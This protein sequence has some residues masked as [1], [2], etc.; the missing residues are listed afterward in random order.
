MNRLDFRVKFFKLN[1]CSAALILPEF[2]RIIQKHSSFLPSQTYHKIIFL[3]CLAGFFLYSPEILFSKNWFDNY[4]HRSKDQIEL[5]EFADRHLTDTRNLLNLN[6]LWEARKKGEKSWTQV[7]VPGAYDFEGEVE[8]KRK[9]AI[10]SSLAGYHFELVAFGIKNRCRLILNNEFLARHEGGHTSFTTD[11]TEKIKPG[12]QNELVIV[13]DNK[14]SPQSSLP[15]KHNPHMPYNYGGIFRDIFIL[16]TPIIFVD[17]LEIRRDFTEDLQRC[18]L[19]VKTHIKDQRAAFEVRDET[20]TAELHLELWDSATEKRIAVSQTESL[21]LGRRLIRREIELTAEDFELWSPEN[22]K[23]YELRAFLTQNRVMVDA[24][25]IR[26]AFKEI[27][28]SNNQYVL[29]G[30]PIALMGLDWFEDFPGGGPTVGWTTL[31]QELMLIKLLGA[32]ALK[33]VGAPPHPFILEICDELGILVFEEPPFCLIPESF[34]DELTFEERI[35]QYYREMLQR[36]SNHASLAGWGLGWDLEPYPQMNELSQKLRREIRE[37]SDLPVYIVYRFL[38]PESI[39]QAAD[40]IFYDFFNQPPDEIMKFAA[41]LNI[42]ASNKAVIFAYGYAVDV[43]NDDLFDANARNVNQSEGNQHEDYLPKSIQ[44]QEVQAYQ[45][46]RVL[47]NEELN[48]QATGM[49]VHTFADWTKND[50]SLIFGAAENPYLNRSGIL[51]FERQKRM[52]YEV[53]ESVFNE[54][55]PVRV[56]FRAVGKQNPNIFPILG[57]L[58]ILVFLF[59]FNRSRRFRINLRRIFIYPHGFY[60]ELKENRK[61]AVWHSFLLSL[62]ICMILSIITASIAFRFRED[63]VFNELLSLFVPSDVVKQKVIWL[64]WR[65][66]VFIPVLFGFFYFGSLFLILILRIAAFVL[67]QRVP[68]SQFFALIFWVAANLI[69]LLPFVPIYY[70]IIN[71]SQWV[72]PAMVLIFLFLLWFAGRLF[73]GVK[74]IFSMSLVQSLVLVFILLVVVLGGIWWYYDVN[75]AAFDYLPLYWRIINASA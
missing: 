58:M 25:T 57:L 23:L 62:L 74:V 28:I 35:V 66:K 34:L 30:N 39:P 13:V 60:M 55:E 26:F 52:S 37:Q 6:G 50:P 38:R 51:D 8:F 48:E 15:L 41:N 7:W 40:L 44:V 70:R 27:S 67:G 24:K 16:T 53:V 32:N 31:K 75:Y 59:N 42:K 12:I 73:R 45:L 11:L 22:P 1:A 36:D 3:V 68:L 56:T 2:M 69:L 64:I 9:F 47:S 72:T 54:L 19:R 17:K 43:E 33:I 10:D 61:I 20:E 14:L 4:L 46:N 21:E 71:H 49:F 65:P 63:L 5:T 18:R 29:N